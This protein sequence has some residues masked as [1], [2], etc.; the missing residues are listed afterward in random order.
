MGEFLST[1][2]TEGIDAMAAISFCEHNSYH[3]LTACV[4]AIS[5]KPCMQPFVEL[6]SLFKVVFVLL[7]ARFCLWRDNLTDLIPGNW[8]SQS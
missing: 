6:L 5:K 3:C 2:E 4:S 7:V 1:T 8:I